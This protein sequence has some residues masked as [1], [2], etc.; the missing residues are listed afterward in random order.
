MRHRQPSGE[1]GGIVACAV[2]I[3]MFSAVLSSADIV[4]PFA[5]ATLWD[6]KFGLII[7][8]PEGQFYLLP[9]LR[10]R[11]AN[12]LRRMLHPPFIIITALILKIKTELPFFASSA[13]GLCIFP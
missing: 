7:Q 4:G 2:S 9:S 10:P 1:F 12:L 11:C 8:H 5:M 13:S 3:N 6:N